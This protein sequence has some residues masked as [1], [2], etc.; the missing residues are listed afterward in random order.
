MDK[1]KRREAL[2]I[3]KKKKAVWHD[4]EK[5][6]KKQDWNYNRRSEMDFRDDDRK[7]QKKTAE[8]K[9]RM[10]NEDFSFLKFLKLVHTIEL[11]TSNALNLNDFAIHIWYSN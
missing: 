5:K 2:K 9:H 6:K 7:K 11:K 1:K 4:L 10:V 3:N 8:N